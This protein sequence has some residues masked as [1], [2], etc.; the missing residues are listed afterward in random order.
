MSQF[1]P[2]VKAITFAKT[3]GVEV[4]EKT[5]LPFP[6]QGP[7]DVIVKV[8]FAGVNFID[9]Y[10]RSGLYSTPLPAIV[11]TEAAGVIA[12]LPTDPAVLNHPE[13]KA[14]GYDKGGKAVVFV[15][16]T[17]AE[18]ISVPWEK[19]Y[20]IPPDSGLD[21]RN[22]AAGFVQTATVL[23]LMNEAYDVKPGDTILI[24]TIA[25]GVGLIGL[26]Y[27]KSKGAT[28]IG[29]TSSE[30]KAKLARAHGADHVILYTKEDIVERVLE[31]TK[32]AG[33]EAVFDGV[34]KDTFDGN[35]KL[36]KRKGTLVSY[37]NASGPVAPFS[38]FKITEKNLK[39]CRP[40]VANYMATPE[41]GTHY[42]KLFFDVM[43]KGIVKPIH[44]FKEYPFTAE[45]TQQ[46]QTDLTGG[47]TT[48]K[49]I[50][51]IGD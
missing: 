8:E 32:G 3:G 31:I 35:L 39:L 18:Y 41:E 7:G 30:E 47:K 29:T 9:T 16:S 24:Y 38:L 44:I 46:A 1:P 45:G 14:R 5:E 43:K 4:I 19:V 25:G 13:Y 12:A 17:N 37:G 49:L 51:K 21:T 48:G 10:F 50:V 34:G 36:L 22:A 23:S 27:A 15:R 20:P 6:Q 42:S 11:G 26:Q 33:V 40:Q 2:T 28:V